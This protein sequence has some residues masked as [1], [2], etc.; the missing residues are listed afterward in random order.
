VLV[1]IHGSEVAPSFDL[2]AYEPV[3][4][5]DYEVVGAGRVPPLEPGTTHWVRDGENAHPVSYG[6]NRDASVEGCPDERKYGCTSR[7][8]SW[9]WAWLILPLLVRR[10]RPDRP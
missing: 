1:A 7:A 10:R 3:Y 2:D 4:V 8:A 6:G 9:S 5:C